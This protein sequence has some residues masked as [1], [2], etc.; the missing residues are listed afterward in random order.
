MSGTMPSGIKFNGPAEFRGG[1]LQHRDAYLGTVTEKFLT[2]ALGRGVEYYDMPVV[3]Q[4]VRDAARADY[5]WSA[6]IVGIAK[7]MPFQMRT[8]GTA[9]QTAANDSQSTRQTRRLQ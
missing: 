5:R 6:M 8:M 3:R 2:Y 4:L 9:A 1:L 7:S